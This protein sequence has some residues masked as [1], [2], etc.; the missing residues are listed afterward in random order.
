M[1]NSEELKK[2]INDQL[3]LQMQ[4]RQTQAKLFDELNKQMEMLNQQ[5][6]AKQNLDLQTQISAQNL[7]ESNKRD[8]GSNNSPEPEPTSDE[9]EVVEVCEICG[10]D[11][12]ESHS[13]PHLTPT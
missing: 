12:H 8:Q 4:Y 10:A 6:T 9:L 3:T 11:N 13:C 1:A 2:L 5:N 7:E